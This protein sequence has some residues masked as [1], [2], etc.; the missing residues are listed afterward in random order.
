MSALLTHF[1]VAIVHHRHKFVVIYPAVLK[2]EHESSI[3]L[4]R[5]DFIQMLKICSV[6]LH[7]PDQPLGSNLPIAYPLCRT[8][9]RL[10]EVHLQWCSR[11]RLYQNTRK[12]QRDD[13]PSELYLDAKLLRW[14]PHSQLFHCYQHLPANSEHMELS[15]ILQPQE[16]TNRK[17]HMFPGVQALHVE[18]WQLKIR[19]HE[20]LWIIWLFS[21]YH[22]AWPFQWKEWM[23]KVKNYLKKQ[24]SVQFWK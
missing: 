6:I 16:N 17:F 11:C 3:K 15:L 9:H 14:I 12:P 4:M 10:V 5:F 22:I 1:I 23:V 13:L 21:W 7:Y 2:N 19:C 20:Q 24:R 18:N 8:R